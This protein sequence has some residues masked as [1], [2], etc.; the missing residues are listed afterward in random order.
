MVKTPS[1][2]ENVMFDGFQDMITVNGKVLK[3][4]GKPLPPYEQSGQGIS[5]VL[6]INEEETKMLCHECGRMFKNVGSH[7]AKKHGIYEKHYKDRHSLLR[8]TALVAPQTRL[9]T[10]NPNISTMARSFNLKEG[11]SNHMKKMAK[12]GKPVRR[13]LTKN[14]YLNRY[15]GCEIQIP[16]R[17][18]AEAERQGVALITLESVSP[19]P[20]LLVKHARRLYGTWAQAKAAISGESALRCGGLLK[21]S[22]QGQVLS[23]FKAYYAIHEIYPYCSDLGINGLPHR[24]TLYRLFGDKKLNSIKR[25]LGWPVNPSGYW[26]QRRNA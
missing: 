19:T 7:A 25:R 20:K 10:G 26:A 3:I 2:E 21:W 24:G 5:G 18:K 6:L 13:G 22:T 14:E 15:A 16:E 1:K 8:Q 4:L 23:A 11:S 12:L 17:M 9:I